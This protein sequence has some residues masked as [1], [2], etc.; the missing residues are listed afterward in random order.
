MIHDN[1]L[2][3][4]IAFT[5]DLLIT[6]IKKCCLDKVLSLSTCLCLLCDCS[7]VLLSPFPLPGLASVVEVTPLII[8]SAFSV[9]LSTNVSIRLL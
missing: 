1:I 7:L 2:I 8:K 6:I 4:T 9:L 5:V 3:K